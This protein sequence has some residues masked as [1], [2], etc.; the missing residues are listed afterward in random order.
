MRNSSLKDIAVAS[1][2]VLGFLLSEDT[3]A[4]SDRVYLYLGLVLLVLWIYL[5]LID[6][7]QGD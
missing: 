2:L 3:D 6:L 4:S 7:F 1:A 5:K